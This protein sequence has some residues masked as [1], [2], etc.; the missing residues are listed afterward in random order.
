MMT[1]EQFR[2]AA[3]AGGGEIRVDKAK[4]MDLMQRRHVALRYAGW[5]LVAMWL[6]LLCPLA[7][8]VC[9]VLGRYVAAIGLLAA[10]PVLREVI[11]HS[12]WRFIVRQAQ[13]DAEFYRQ[14]VACGALQID[15]P[16]PSKA[17]AA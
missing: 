6:W 13:A 5:R 17:A 12:S 9:M 1:H 14:A 16:R 7:G 8:V 11:L 3:A 10:C 15:H 2:Q 4:A